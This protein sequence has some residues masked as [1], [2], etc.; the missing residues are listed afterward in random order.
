M[1]YKRKQKLRRENKWESKMGLLFGSLK[2]PNNPI[3]LL[4]F[5]AYKYC[6]GG[7]MFLACKL[8]AI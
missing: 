6:G 1:K 5:K 4:Q 7:G 3:F 8:S 2:Y